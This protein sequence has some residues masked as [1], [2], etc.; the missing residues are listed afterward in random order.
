MAD[1]KITSS[2][3]RF[4]HFDFDFDAELRDREFVAAL[5]VEQC[6]QCCVILISLYIFKAE[7]F[8]T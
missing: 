7:V 5:K 8:N 3:I 2:M 1:L 6:A 4:Y